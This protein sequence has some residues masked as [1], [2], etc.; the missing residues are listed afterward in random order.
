MLTI[1]LVAVFGIVASLGQASYGS[2]SDKEFEYW[3][4]AE[5]DPT[6]FDPPI[7]FIDDVSPE[8]CQA[9]CA[10]QLL[11]AISP[12]SVFSRSVCQ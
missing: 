9:V 8:A 10:G 11:A 2:D 4:C 6:G 5:V 1:L 7:Q 3:G 12:E